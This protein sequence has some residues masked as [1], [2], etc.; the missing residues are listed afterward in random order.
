MKTTLIILMTLLLT[1]GGCT[2]EERESKHNNRCNFVLIDSEQYNNLTTDDFNIVD[3]KFE[4]RCLKITIRY[5]GGCKDVSLR[6]IDS[7]SVFGSNPVQRNLKIILAD[8][9]DCEALITKEF[10]FD[11]TKLKVEGQNEVL[12]NFFESNKTHLYTY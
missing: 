12:L 8:D 5:G 1:T 11:I 4:D 6:L 10:Y 2:K 9:D 7:D 3:I